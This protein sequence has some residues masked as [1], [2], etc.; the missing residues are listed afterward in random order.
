M[1]KLNDQRLKRFQNQEKH[2]GSQTNTTVCLECHDS[3]IQTRN[4][5]M[6]ALV[7]VSEQSDLTPQSV[8]LTLGQDSSRFWRRSPRAVDKHVLISTM[9]L[10]SQRPQPNVDLLLS[11][12]NNHSPDKFTA[13]DVQPLFENAK[14]AQALEGIL[15]ASLEGQNDNVLS[16]D[17]LRV[18]ASC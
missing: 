18:Y 8:T 1:N 6:M 13:K 3:I 7:F 12:L 14:V 9:N 17:E 15:D 5:K 2:P 16:V 4:G 11:F 10:S